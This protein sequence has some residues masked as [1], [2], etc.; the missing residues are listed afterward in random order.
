MKAEFSDCWT[1]YFYIAHLG[2]ELT[3]HN[4]DIVTG[5]ALIG[6]IQELIKGF[7]GYI[8]FIFCRGVCAYQSNIK[9]FNSNADCGESLVH[10]CALQNKAS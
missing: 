8:I 6:L 2:V 4:F 5:A 3:K 9:I 1:N 10:R 7:F